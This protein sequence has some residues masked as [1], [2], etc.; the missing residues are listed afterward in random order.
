MAN[1][2]EIERLLLAANYDLEAAERL[3]VAPPIPL[4]A[5]HLQQAAEKILKAVRVHRGL[6]KQQSITSRF[7]SMATKP[8]AKNLC[9][10]WQAIRGEASSTRW[11]DSLPMPQRTA[12]R[13]QTSPRYTNS[14]CGS[15]P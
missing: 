15:Q 3:L 7:S 6:E 13:C 2:K 12:I 9:H 4:A 14:R 1:N 11:W 10:S 5:N 8:L